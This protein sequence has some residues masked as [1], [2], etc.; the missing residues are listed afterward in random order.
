[1]KTQ[2]VLKKYKNL[3]VATGH[4]M[5]GVSLGPVTGN[6]IAQLASDEQPKMDISLLNVDRY[7]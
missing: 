5:L 4:A 7:N 3:M 2:G 6:I 1:M